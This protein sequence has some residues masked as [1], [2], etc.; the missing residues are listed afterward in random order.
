[1]R[2]S[3]CSGC[4][5]T[6][7]GIATQLG[8][9][10]MPLGMF[11]NSFELTSGTT[12]GTSGSIRHAD[13]LSTTTAPALAAIG[14]NSRLTDAGVLDSTRSTPANASARMGSTVYVW[15]RKGIGLP[16]DFADARNLIDFTGKSR[17]TSTRRKN[18]PTA[19]VAPTTA[20]FGIT[21]EA[22]G[23]KIGRA[24]V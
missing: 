21:F 2:A 8:L 6:H 10:T 17:S 18:S 1:M 11:F 22:L 23:V 16:A 20:T 13:E 15:P 24:H 14:L 3:A 12:S 4:T 7:S 9:A 5:A 19:P